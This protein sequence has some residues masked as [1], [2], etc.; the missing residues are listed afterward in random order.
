M[1]RGTSARVAGGQVD[2]ATCAGEAHEERGPACGSP[3]SWPHVLCAA[4]LQRRWAQLWLQE[5]QVSWGTDERRAPS[6]AVWAWPWGALRMDG[7]RAHGDL[8]WVPPEASASTGAGF[9][10]LRERAPICSQ[11]LSS[12]VGSQFHQG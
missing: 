8:G 6:G 2:T 7:G 3:H 10:L 4:V 1:E 9:P 11:F 5:L 12:H